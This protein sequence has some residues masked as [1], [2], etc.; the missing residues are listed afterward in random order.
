MIQLLFESCH[1][2]HGNYSGHIINSDLCSNFAKYLKVEGGTFV[3]EITLYLTVY[4]DLAADE[5]YDV[6]GAAE[7]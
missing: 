2:K 4:L 6:T 7:H 5:G 3:L 1:F